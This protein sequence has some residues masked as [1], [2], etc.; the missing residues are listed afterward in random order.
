[1]GAW[2]SFTKTCWSLAKGYSLVLMPSSA[3]ADC[4]QRCLAAKG[5]GGKTSEKQM[6]IL[7]VKIGGETHRMKTPK[8]YKQN[9]NIAN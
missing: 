5:F 3:R 2:V 9:I 7:A 1:M 8:V 6:Q 4:T